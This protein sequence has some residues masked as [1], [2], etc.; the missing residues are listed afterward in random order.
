MKVILCLFLHL[1]YVAVV[2]TA[3]GYGN[4]VV[5]LNT[6]NVV[7]LWNALKEVRCDWNGECN[8][9]CVFF[10]TKN[11]FDLLFLLLGGT[12]N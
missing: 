1:T 2:I 7:V 9:K 5:P 6:F 4:P 10:N 12:E 3:I 11:Y 8:C